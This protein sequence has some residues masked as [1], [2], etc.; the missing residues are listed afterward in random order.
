M[1]DNWLLLRLMTAY[2][3]ST[4]SNIFSLP[5]YLCTY[6]VHVARRAPAWHPAVGIA[7]HAPPASEVSPAPAHAAGCWS[8]VRMGRMAFS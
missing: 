1:L 7:A 3:R 5:K 2:G 4:K 8:P 6:E